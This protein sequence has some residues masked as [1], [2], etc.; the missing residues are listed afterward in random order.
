MENDIV[1]IT[2]VIAYIS[3]SAAAVLYIIETIIAMSEKKKE[4]EKKQNVERPRRGSSH[5][6]YRRSIRRSANLENG[7]EPN[8]LK[9]Q[10]TNDQTLTSISENDSEESLGFDDIYENQDENEVFL[11]N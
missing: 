2:E 11:S 10:I 1:T 9:P 6:Q 5:W 4:D 3:A 8:V 7:E